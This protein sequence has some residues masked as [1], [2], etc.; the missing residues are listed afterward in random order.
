MAKQEDSE[1]A[2][3]D[4][5]F[6]ANLTPHEKLILQYISHG[7]TVEETAIQMNRTTFAV[8][9]SMSEIRRKLRAKNQAQAVRN[10]LRLGLID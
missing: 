5:D 10:A 9:N 1:L 7:M 2:E 3:L 8:G 4:L 6:Y